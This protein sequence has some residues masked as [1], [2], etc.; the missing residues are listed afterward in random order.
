MRFV[1]G[2]LSC[3]KLLNALLPLSVW[4]MIYCWILIFSSL[5]VT[6]STGTVYRV[7]YFSYSYSIRDLS[8]F[9]VRPYSDMAGVF[10]FSAMGTA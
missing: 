3:L 10:V 7:K 2:E 6:C 8:P 5:L 4:Y 1:I 9:S